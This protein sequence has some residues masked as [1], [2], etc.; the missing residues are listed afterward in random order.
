M[1][2]LFTRVIRRELPAHIVA[3]NEDYIAFLD[4][5]PLQIGH[6][7]VVPKAEIDYIFDQS[8]SVLSNLLPFA[9]EVAQRLEAVVSCKRIGVSVVGLEVPHTHLH[10]IPIHHVTDMDF[11]NAKLSPTEAD[12]MDL[13]S[14]IREA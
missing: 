9:R 3:E 2:T 8:A 4:I 11:S 5:H 14:R 6:T 7:L 12:L 13:A 10:L 1:P